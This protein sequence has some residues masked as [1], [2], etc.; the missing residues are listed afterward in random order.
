MQEIVNC[1]KACNF[2]HPYGKGQA[3]LVRSVKWNRS[4]VTPIISRLYQ[5]IRNEIQ[6]FVGNSAMLRRSYRVQSKVNDIMSVVI[7]KI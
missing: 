4:I 2:N 1:N 6:Y 7:N 5:I 3:K